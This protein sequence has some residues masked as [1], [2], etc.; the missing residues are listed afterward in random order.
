MVAGRRPQGAGTAEG[1]PLGEAP[2]LLT[3][4]GFSARH[5]FTTRAGGSSSGSFASLNLGLSSGDEPGSVEANRERL[6]AHLGVSRAQVCG[7]HQ[8][9]GDTVALASPGWFE[10]PADACV[11]DDPELLLVVSAADCFPLLFHD[12][13]S[14]AVGAAHCGWRGTEARLASKVVAELSR[15]FGAAPESLEVAIGQGIMGACY[16]VSHEVGERFTAAGFPGSVLAYPAAAERPRLDLLA[17]L[18]S[19]LEQAGVSP[20]RIAAVERCTHC[21][22][23]TFFSHRRD[24]GTTGRMWGFVRAGRAPR[25]AASA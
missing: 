2:P 20:A 6:L 16:E 8:V 15:R 17:A 1:E 9:H 5:G 4:A 11:S 3:L 22:P 19:D 24:A 12:P 14:G 18:R 23:Q 13:V 10:R 25:G 21:E 7:Y